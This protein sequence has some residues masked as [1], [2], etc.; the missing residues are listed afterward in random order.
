MQ[1][2]YMRHNNDCYTCC[3]ATV[4]GLEYESVPR[5]FDDDDNLVLDWGV[6]VSEFLRRHGYQ[7][8]SVT[9]DISAIRAMQGLCIVAGPSYSERYKG[10]GTYH[11]VVYRDGHLWHDP[12]PNPEGVIEPE[13]M[14]LIVPIFGGV[15]HA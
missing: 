8:V 5:F 2:V 3:L 12:K 15:A 4:L 9:A 1:K 14:D 13:L 11:A 7:L 6:A 10:T